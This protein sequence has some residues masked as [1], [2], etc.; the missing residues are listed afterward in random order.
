MTTAGRPAGRPVS[1]AAG[2]S[3][4]AGWP[5]GRPACRGRPTGWLVGRSTGRPKYSYSIHLLTNT[6]FTTAGSWCLLVVGTFSRGLPLAGRPA[7]QPVGRLAGP[8]AGQPAG[9]PAAQPA[10]VDWLTDRPTGRLFLLSRFQP[11]P[12]SARPG[13]SFCFFCVL[14]VCLLF[15]L[16]V[17]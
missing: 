15:Q 8:P 1:R 10:P 6:P 3:A 16:F 9:Q 17:W 5:T 13:F 4:S 11:P 7:D 12:S 14:L 2:R